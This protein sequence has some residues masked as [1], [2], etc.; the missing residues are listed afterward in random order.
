MKF[1]LIA[2]IVL[3]SLAQGSFAQDTADLEKF[4]QYLE[5]MKNKMVQDLTEIMSTHDVANQAQ[6]FVNEKRV[7]LEPLVS[8][9]HEQLKTIATN[10]EA[11][12]K[13]LA[14]NVQSQFQPQI[15]SFQQQVE[16]IFQQLTKPAAPIAN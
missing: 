9:I 16:A 15:D 13:P 7:Q 4:G 5:E 11:Q 2:A 8:Q 10:A 14:A 6:S 12:I 1:S 3:L